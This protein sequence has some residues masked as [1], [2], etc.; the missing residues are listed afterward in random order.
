[1]NGKFEFTREVPSPI[2]P[3]MDFESRRHSH[4]KKKLKNKKDEYELEALHEVKIAN[5]ASKNPE[6]YEKINS[7]IR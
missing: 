1:M 3:P 4:Q 2:G 7:K 6:K 5:E